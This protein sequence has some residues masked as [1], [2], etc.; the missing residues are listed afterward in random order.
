MNE[1]KVITRFAPSPTG[2]L[3]IGG[4]R[5]ALY[6]YLFA[7]VSGG[8]FLLRIEDTD[9]SRYVAGAEEKLQESLF[10]A[11]LTWDNNEV[12]HQSQRK[13]I[14]KKYVDKLLE[15]GKAYHCFCSSER[16][17][18]MR[19]EQQKR[20]EAPRYD[21]TCLDFDKEAIQKKL[22]CGEQSVI[23]FRVPDESVE[24][25]EF[26]DAIRGKIGM[27]SEL[28]DDQV[29]L[30]SD[31]FPTYHLASVVDD[32]LS[33]ITHIIRGEEWL[34]ST[35]KHIL[36]YQ[37]FGWEIPIFAHLPL[38]L[39]SDRSKL[40]KRQGDVSVE[41]YRK[42]GYLS[43]AL[44]NYVA[45]LGWN[46]G[47]GSTQELFS[48]EELETVFSLKQINKAGAVFDPK[49]LDWMNGQYIK[50][51]DPE[52]L[53]E[54]SLPFWDE[55]FEE[56]SLEKKDFDREYLQRVFAV[57]R[58]RLQRLCD[59]GKENVFFFAFSGV[60]KDAL[61]FKDG[62][63]ENIQ[64]NL[65]KALEVL[66]DIEESDWTRD[67]LQ[68][69]FLAQCDDDKRGEFFWPLRVA[70]TGEKKSPPPHEVAWVI[71]KEETFQRV[72][73]ALQLFVG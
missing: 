18:Q 22:A 26:R 41:D 11:N 8:E 62:S 3:H 36:L 30:K 39:N 50:S 37:A 20:G 4:L 21:R 25:V 72:N 24:Q 61:R 5:T 9:Q 49:R 44:V 14:Y 28:I 33:E 38:L 1:K 19:K 45:L 73:K 57:E 55:F 27:K 43:L 54:Q 42:K 68:Q 35:P 60:E 15:E 67:N 6:N 40:S 63:D 31:G 32:H 16:L 70:L 48:L 71:G 66:K 64:T 52:V 10:W 65:T 7:R 69:I 53:F 13:E 2:Y 59:V 56:F 17:K 23:R 29:I 51:G 34:P 47:S 58:E 12:W 46:P